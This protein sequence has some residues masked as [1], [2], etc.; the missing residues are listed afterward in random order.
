[1]TLGWL[2]RAKV[3]HGILTNMHV[4]LDYGTLASELP[5]GVE[6]AYDGMQVAFEI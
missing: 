2:Q 5:D 1:M 3:R 6:P 4:D